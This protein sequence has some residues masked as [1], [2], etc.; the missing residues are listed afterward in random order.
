L[1]SGRTR[2]TYGVVIVVVARHDAPKK[3]EYSLSLMNSRMSRETLQ[4]E[5]VPMKTEIP[6]CSCKVEYN[7][8]KLSF[9]D[10]GR[11]L[12]LNAVISIILF[13]TEQDEPPC[14]TNERIKSVNFLLGIVVVELPLQVFFIVSSTRRN[15]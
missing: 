1:T 11:P 10:T 2:G 8:H 6:A 3:A 4:Y 5:I 13:L 12:L 14:L 15:P 7:N 9:Q